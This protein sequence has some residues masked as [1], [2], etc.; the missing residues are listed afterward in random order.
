ML[1]QPSSPSHSRAE[2]PTR[3]PQ[4]LQLQ[5][6][7]HRN[8]TRTVRQNRRPSTETTPPPPIVSAQPQLSNISYVTAEMTPSKNYDE[9][10][11]AFT[12]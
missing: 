6:Q 9:V 1:S 8:Q 4:S 11:K 7:P 10:S 2:S 3:Q 5:S 12:Q